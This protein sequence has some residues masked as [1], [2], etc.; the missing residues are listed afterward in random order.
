MQAYHRVSYVLWQRDAQSLGAWRSGTQS[1]FWK[2]GNR[3]GL[4]GRR[5]FESP[6]RFRRVQVRGNLFLAEKTAFVKARKQDNSN[7]LGS[8]VHCLGLAEK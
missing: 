6:V 4:E 1:N 5:T 7:R 3:E 8:Q 2:G